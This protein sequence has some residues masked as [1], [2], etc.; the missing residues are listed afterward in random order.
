MRLKINTYLKKWI[1]VNLETQIKEIYHNIR[2]KASN[3]RK[4]K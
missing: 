4:T 3:M 1:G 2:N